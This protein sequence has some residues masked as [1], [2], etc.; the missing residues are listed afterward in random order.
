MPRLWWIEMTTSKDARDWSSKRGAER[1]AEVIRDYWRR[2][3]KRALV[4]ITIEPDPVREDG[5]RG[6]QLYHVRLVGLE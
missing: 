2:Q 6:S 3:G 5:A 4:E 1:L